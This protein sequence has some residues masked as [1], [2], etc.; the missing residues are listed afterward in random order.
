MAIGSSRGT[1]Q[2]A[3]RGRLR[4]QPNKYVVGGRDDDLTRARAPHWQLRPNVSPGGRVVSVAVGGRAVHLVEGCA[5]AD[6][7]RVE[8][9]PDVSRRPRAESWRDRRDTERS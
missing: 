4:S 9:S 2:A 6:R 1:L 8:G 7:G 5:S 3:Y